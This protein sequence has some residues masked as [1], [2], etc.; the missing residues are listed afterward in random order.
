MAANKYVCKVCGYT[1]EGDAAPA[2]CPLC[3]AAASEFEQVG[4]EKNEKTAKKG[5][6]T[7]SDS[8]AIIYAS[9]V[10]VIVAFLLAG[11]S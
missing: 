5:F 7:A 3:K 1:H 4:G 9:I 8:Y 2:A 10:V 6:N 11:V